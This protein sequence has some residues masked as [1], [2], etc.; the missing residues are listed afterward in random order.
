[1]PE[2]VTAGGDTGLKQT[3]EIAWSNE[4]LNIEEIAAIMPRRRR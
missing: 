2:G 1:M 3:T 4:F